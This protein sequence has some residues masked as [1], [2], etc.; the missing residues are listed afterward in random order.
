[1]A[2][3]DLVD[4]LSIKLAELGG[5]CRSGGQAVNQT[6]WVAAVDLVDRLSV[7]LAE[8]GGCCCRSG[9]QAVNQAS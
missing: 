6:S 9:G 7:K 5:C 2:A 4:R 1:M 8:L 3:V